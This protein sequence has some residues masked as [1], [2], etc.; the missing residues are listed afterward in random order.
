MLFQIPQFID[1]EDKI[2]GPFSLK[3]FLFLAGA[4]GICFALFFVL[5]KG[6]WFFITAIV[7]GVAAAAA[8]GRYNGQPLPKIA[9]FA[10]NYFWKP[11]LFLWQREAET[12]TIS[13]P[14][15]PVENKRKNLEKFFSEMP[16]VKK[17]WQDLATT[18]NPIPKREKSV[19]SISTERKEKYELFRKTSGEKMIARR[20]DYR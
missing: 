3:Q 6:L 10:F 18:K 11:R 12:K 17:L 9:W 1:V 19:T 2:V 15:M 20:V 7:G 5:N 4:A 8:F 16:S 13:L 14:E